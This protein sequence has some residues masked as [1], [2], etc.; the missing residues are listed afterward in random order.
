MDTIE[1][2]AQRQSFTDLEKK[3]LTTKIKKMWGMEKSVPSGL[4]QTKICT[5]L[6]IK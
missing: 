3:L 2:L 4:L 1:L 5:L 6:F